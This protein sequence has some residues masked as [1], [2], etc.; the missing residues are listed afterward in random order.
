MLN[1]AYLLLDEVT[2]NMD[3]YAEQAV[4]KALL[5]LMEG[6]TT[7]MITHDMRMLEHADHVIVL[8]RGKIEAEGGTEEV[9][10]SSE[11]LRRLVAVN[12]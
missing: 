1:P 9:K 3:V 5:R 10:Q 11:T 8:N 2:C 7:V 12:V 4:T 6:R